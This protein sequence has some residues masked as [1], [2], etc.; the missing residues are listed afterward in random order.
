MKIITYNIANYD[1][2]PYWD[3]RVDMIAD[4]LIEHEPDLVAFQEV[5]FNPAQTSTENSYQD[6]AQQVI[7]NIRMKKDESWINSTIITQPVMYYYKPGNS[8]HWQYP[9]KENP[10]QFWEGKSIVSRTQP[11]VE[12]GNLFLKM[13]NASDANRRS[14]CYVLDSERFYLFNSH[15]SYDTEN[16]YE[17][18]R[19]TVEYM[20]R[21]T[22]GAPHILVGDLNAKPTDKAMEP[23]KDAG[24]IDLWSRLYPE[25]NGYT[26]STGNLEKRIDYMWASSQEIADKAKSI[27]LL[28]DQ[29]REIELPGG[30]DKKIY[31]S[32]HL[33]LCLTL[34]L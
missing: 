7:D 15:F 17:N 16:A 26:E 13:E 12:A 19:Q 34:D 4:I 20:D 6:M 27:E 31:P 18:S 32:D 33:G 24:Y 5:R 1:D 9:R 23:L 25:D 10:N 8:P 22:N 14:T 29:Y 11:I 30:Q 21:V 2:H 28:G 3:T